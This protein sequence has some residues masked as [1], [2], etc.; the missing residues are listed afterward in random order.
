MPNIYIYT[1]RKCRSSA[2][3]FYY[4]YFD[5]QLLIRNSSVIIL[6]SYENENSKD[7]LIVGFNFRYSY[8]VLHCCK[9]TH[10]DYVQVRSPQN[11]N[12]YDIWYS[13]KTSPTS[14][15]NIAK[16]FNYYYYVFFEKEISFECE[17]NA[18]F[19]RFWIWMK[20]KSNHHSHRP[21]TIPSYVL[22][23]K[24]V[25]TFIL[26]PNTKSHIPTTLTRHSL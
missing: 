10:K 13:N 2:I 6:S 18:Y 26:V 23:V 22:D 5:E 20:L 12:V 9:F 24:D 7:P 3:I 1:F 21:W 17:I 19:D 15:H 4:I 11:E 25:I 16:I 14:G 8:L